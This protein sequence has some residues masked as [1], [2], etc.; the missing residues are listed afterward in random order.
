[1]LATVTLGYPL[2]VLMTLET[3][4]PGT[5]FK[6]RLLDGAEAS[7]DIEPEQ[8][9]MDGQQRLT[10]LYRLGAA[11][12]SMQWSGIRSRPRQPAW[13]VPGQCLARW[14]R[15]GEFVVCLAAHW[16]SWR[17]ASTLRVAQD[18]DSLF[19]LR[20]VVRADQGGDPM[21]VPGQPEGGQHLAAAGSRL[22]L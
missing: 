9:L 3:G 7:S 22:D 14:R 16:R 5:R 15:E 21:A 13:A 17:M 12:G 8:L 6:P 20:K 18:V 4:G 2:G 11:D 19:E 1:M 10:S